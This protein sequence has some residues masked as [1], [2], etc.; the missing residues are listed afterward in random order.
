MIKHIFI[1]WN[2]GFLNAPL[3]VKKCLLSWKIY[4]PNWKIIELDDSN[5][6]Q[7]INIELVITNI[8]SKTITKTSYSDIIRIFLLKKYGGIWCDA[9]VF[10]VKSLDEWLS[11]NIISGFFAFEQKCDR[12]LSSWFLY[13]DYNNYIIDK[14]YDNVIQYINN[15]NNTDNI[16]LHHDCITIYEW[17]KNKYSYGHYFWFHYL[18]GDLYNNDLLF[19]K[20]YDN[21]TKISASEPQYLQSLNLLNDIKDDA[22]NHINNKK[23]PLYKLTYKYKDN[24]NN[25]SILSYLLSLYKIYFIHI[26]KCAG[27]TIVKYFNFEQFHLTK[28]KYELN[29]FYI[30]WIRNP[31]NRFVSAFNFAHSII[32][33]NTSILNINNLTLD[34]CLAP[35][36]IAYKMKNNHTFS[37][38][39]DEL[40]NYFST[41]NNLA[42]SITSTDINIQQK[43][44]LL[45]NHSLEHINNGIGWYLDNGD[46]I[47]KYHKNILFVGKLENMNEDINKLCNLLNIH[48][49]S[50]IKK[51]RENNINT[52]KILSKLAIENIINFYK[53]T[54]YKAIEV[55]I[56]YKFI[57]KDTLDE[58]YKYNNI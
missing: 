30:I 17:N 42:E 38:E 21:T 6:N 43:A 32:N 3:V 18:F 46:F 54:D 9:T 35:V 36:R 12:I 48:P 1:Y 40:I 5:L 14:W 56:K 39:Y 27:S 34:N 41:P 58:Y 26:G 15:V 55:L 24:N 29:Y 37:N 19:K 57:K 16:G 45:M 8:S 33:T 23:S 2:S 20:M 4:N 10:C 49:P 13:S 44:L 52:N 53:N 51:V 31:I 50:E 7:Y 22:L 25:N 11:D 28:P 47:E